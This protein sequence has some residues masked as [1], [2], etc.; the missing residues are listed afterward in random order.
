MHLRPLLTPAFSAF[1]LLFW[2]LNGL[3]KFFYRSTLGLFN[4]HGKDRT[5]QFT[6]YFTSLGFP[7]APIG[8]ILACT[9][10]IEIIVALPFA[11]TLPNLLSATPMKFERGLRQLQRALAIALT[12]FLGFISFDVIAGDRAELLEHSTYLAVIAATLLVGYVEMMLMGRVAEVFE[13]SAKH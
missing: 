3:D 1:W 2:L 4:W 5:E 7:Q 8:D 10:V 6:G 9:G 12:I 13:P 11:I